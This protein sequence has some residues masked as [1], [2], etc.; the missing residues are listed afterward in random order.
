M[1]CDS[2]FMCS[3]ESC[4]AAFPFP[5]GG[6]VSFS[7]ELFRSHGTRLWWCHM[8]FLHLCFPITG[9]F[10]RV[11]SFL[12][13]TFP[14]AL[15]LLIV[16]VSCGYVHTCRCIMGLLTLNVKGWVVH[17]L[18]FKHLS[19]ALLW[20]G[21]VP[22][23]CSCVHFCFLIGSINRRGRIHLPGLYY[24]QYVYYVYLVVILLRWNCIAYCF[25]LLRHRPLSYNIS[26]GRLVKIVSFCLICLR[27][28]QSWFM[29]PCLLQP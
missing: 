28:W 4:Y 29:W 13:D 9:I 17:F 8:F 18:S 22:V 10:F 2:L 23:H 15:R 6:V 19:D 20:L 5:S 3:F 26:P 12:W 1:L 24:I 14:P 21:Y 25:H 11:H 27:R 7:L 16:Y